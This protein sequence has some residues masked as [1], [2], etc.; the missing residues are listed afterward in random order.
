MS[1]LNSLDVLNPQFNNPLWLPLFLDVAP[2][3]TPGRSL[4]TAISV[5]TLTHELH[6][7]LL[8]KSGDLAVVGLPLS[9][10]P[11]WRARHLVYE[12]IKQLPQRAHILQLSQCPSD[13]PPFAAGAASRRGG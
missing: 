8:T 3:P 11:Q 1:L 7:S 12:H 4:N 5:G 9:L 13:F 10:G 2:T 6:F